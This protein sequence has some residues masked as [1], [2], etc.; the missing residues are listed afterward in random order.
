MRVSEDPY[1]A[2][3]ALACSGMRDL[4]SGRRSPA[5]RLI[6]H[7]PPEQQRSL[8]RLVAP[9]SSVGPDFLSPREPGL[10]TVVAQELDRLRDLSVTELQRD[11]EVTFEGQPPPQWRQIANHPRTWVT[12]TADALDRLWT[13]AEPVWRR[14]Q[15]LRE[16]HAERVGAAASRGV[17]DTL[18]GELHPR[19]W[20][21]EGALVFPDPEGTEVDARQRPVVLAPIL[22]TLDIS[23]SNLER[24]DGVWMAFPV[25]RIDPPD[26]DGLSSLLTPIRAELLKLLNLERGMSEVATMLGVSPAAATHQVDALVVAGLVDRHR[27]GRR[28]LVRRSTRGDG[29]LALYGVETTSRS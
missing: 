14:E 13:A 3:L 10:S 7:L 28:V 4:L 20:S 26:P 22:S 27:D 12:H 23:I 11:F 29:I 25:G 21:E 18:L 16:R 24:P 19:G 8:A 5:A 2:V 1:G 17:L 6:G 9:G 15:R